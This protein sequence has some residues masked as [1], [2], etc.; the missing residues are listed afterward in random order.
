MLAGCLRSCAL[1]IEVVLDSGLEGLGVGTND[2]RNLVA[3]LEKKEGR[4][5]ADTEVSC[6]LGEFVDVEL[7]E[8]RAGV[9]FGEPRKRSIAVNYQGKME[10]YLTTWGAITLQ[11]PHHVAKQSR[12]MRLSFTAMA[13]SKSLCLPCHR[14][15][16]CPAHMT[17]RITRGMRRECNLLHQVV[18][19]L[20][21]VAHFGC[22]GEELLGEEWSIEV[23]GR[24]G[25]N[26]CL[27]ACRCEQCS[28]GSEG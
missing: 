13:S 17:S 9:L 7:V 14:V 8:A 27:Q 24:C 15:S 18:Y 19:T 3:V 4:H 12:T 1:C 2:L 11:G 22:V 25:V 10:T 26:S 28:G 20:L 5:G 16:P 23:C 21:F 6:D